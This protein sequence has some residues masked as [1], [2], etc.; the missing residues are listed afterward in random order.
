MAQWQQRNEAVQ[1]QLE[2]YDRRACSGPTQL[3]YHFDH[4]VLDEQ[5]VSLSHDR[6]RI[7]EMAFDLDLSSPYEDML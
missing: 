5:H 1:E 7:G 3:V 2:L 6:L 4:Q